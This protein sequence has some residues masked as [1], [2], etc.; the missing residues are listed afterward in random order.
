VRVTTTLV[1]GPFETNNRVTTRLNSVE[2]FI[3]ASFELCQ[4]CA[5]WSLLNLCAAFLLQHMAISS[6]PS[7]LACPL[8]SFI[9]VV[10]NLL[11]QLVLTGV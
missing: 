8:V 5:A 4:G 3:I 7:H 6:D 10:R 11:D 1:N 9:Q 2:S